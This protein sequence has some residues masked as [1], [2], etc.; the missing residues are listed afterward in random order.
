[1]IP[2]SRKEQGLMLGRSARENVSL[3]HLARF[4]RAGVV[5]QG[6]AHVRMRSLSLFWANSTAHRHISKH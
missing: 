5:A 3:P 6:P 2:E 1:M 4:S